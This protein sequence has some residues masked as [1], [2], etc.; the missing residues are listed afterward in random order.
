M[1]QNPITVTE[2]TPAPRGGADAP[3]D[4]VRRAA[5]RSATAGWWGSSPTPTSCGCLVGA[6]RARRM[7]RPDRS[8]PVAG[9]APDADVE[10]SSDGYA[11]RFAGAVGAWFLDVQA[12]TTLELLAP[13]PR[14]AR[15]GRRAAATASSRRPWLGAGPRR[16]GARQRAPA[17]PPASGPGSESGQVALR[18]RRPRRAFPFADRTFDV[19]PGVPP[20]APRPGTGGTSSRELCRV[21]RRAVVVDY[22]TRRSVNAVSGLLF[23]LKKR[24]EGDT[25]PFPCSR[26]RE[27][28]AAFATSGFDAIGAASRSSCSPWPLHRAL[29]IAGSVA[30][31]RRRGAGR[32]AAPFAGIARHPAARS[33]VAERLGGGRSSADRVLKQRKHAEIAARAGPDGGPAL[34]RPRLGQRRGQPPAAPRGRHAGPR[35]T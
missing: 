3:Y 28:R 4:Q 11:R 1:I 21:A 10:T 12:R 14:G 2:E 7:S 30:P 34:P 25:R 8:A 33:A 27:V 20:P 18:R 32:R 31:P 26:T 35:P 6:A 23:G 9:A 17:A 15:P 29:G 24:V 5:R 22:P 19:V 13:W 16:D